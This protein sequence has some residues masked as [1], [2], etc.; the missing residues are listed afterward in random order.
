MIRGYRKPPEN[1]P[2]KRREFP[3]DGSR[4]NQILKSLVFGI[5]APGSSGTGALIEIDLQEQEV[6]GSELAGV[7]VVKVEL[8]GGRQVDN[9]VDVD[10]GHLGLHLG[11]RGQAWGAD[12]HRDIAARAG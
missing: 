12:D 11:E 7:D 9:R 4:Q 10:I 1:L 3:G 6:V 8:V 2:A 5:F